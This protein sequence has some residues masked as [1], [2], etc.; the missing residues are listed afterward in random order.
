MRG[1]YKNPEATAAVLHARRLAAH[2]RPGPPRRRRL[3]LRHRP[4]QGADHQGRREH[5]PARDRR[6]AAEAP[7]GAGR[8][9]GGHPRPALRPGDHGLRGA[10]RGPWPATRPTTARLLRA[11]AGP[12]QDAEAV[13]ASWP[14]CRAGRRARCSGASCHARPAGPAAGAAG[15]GRP[16]A[17]RAAHPAP[18]GSRNSRP[19]SGAW[20][21]AGCPAR[22]GA[23]ARPRPPAASCSRLTSASATSRKAVCVARCQPTAACSATVRASSVRAWL[24]PASKSDTS[25]DGPMDQM[26]APP[27]AG[28]PGRRSGRRS[29]RSAPAW[30]RRSCA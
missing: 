30:A 23:G 12:L 27:S 1:Y 24:R 18:P 15:P 14:T 4:H 10:A 5:R 17:C 22:R 9:G 20:P 16:P 13:S 7:G 26:R 6:G 29:C 2:R 3:L 25:S 8:R 19:R 11:A 28:R 21:G